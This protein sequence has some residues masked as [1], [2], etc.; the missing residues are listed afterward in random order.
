[1]ILV[2]SGL[3]LKTTRVLSLSGLGLVSVVGGILALAAGP[4][5]GAVATDPVRQLRNKVNAGSVTL[6]FEGKQGYLRSV[7]RE[8]DIDP[9]SQVLVF[10][11]TSL[12]TNY[13]EPKN[14]RAIY[15]NDTT[16]VAYIPG[17]P[18]MEIL[19]VDPKQG[20]RSY[21]IQNRSADQAPFANQEGGCAQCHGALMATQAPTLF[22]QSATV[23]EVGHPRMGGLGYT[24]SPRLP[25][26][27]RWGGWYVT[28]DHGKLRHMGNEI[29]VG[30][31]A[32]HRIDTERGANVK[33]LAR[34]FDTSKHLTPH[35]DVVAL[36]VLENQM[37][38]SN[39]ISDAVVRTST[40]L[41]KG[42]TTAEMVAELNDECEPVV[43]SLFGSNEA[44]ITSPIIGTSGFIEY[45]SK[46]GPRDSN[47]R[48]L[49]ELDMTKRIQKYPFNRLVYS[50]SFGSLPDVAR[51]RIFSRVEQILSGN[52]KTEAFSHLSAADRKAVREILIDTL[53]SFAAFVRNR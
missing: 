51:D 36:M 13:I 14:P 35:S 37:D 32:S 26:S 19:S 40:L 2:F 11:K 33:S 9:S 44:P 15:F 17:A 3:N 31:D 47:G 41:K 20:P 10:S 52:D 8:L 50:A 49:S 22:A 48:S 27:K 12:Q 24:L 6:K 29:A 16:Y 4:D 7:L 21:T 34:Y 1:L 38:V 42:L 18:F 25:I 23:D 45:Y 43:Q 39:T 46:Q 30:T 53:P 5:Q 28:G